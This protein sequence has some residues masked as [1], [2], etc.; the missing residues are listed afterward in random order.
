MKGSASSSRSAR[1]QARRRSA[2]GSPCPGW[3]P[4]AASA[5]TASTVGRRCARSRSTPGTA[6]TAPMPSTPPRT[7]PTSRK[8][9]DAVD[10]LDA[11]A[12]DLRRRHD[13]QGGQGVRCPAGSAG[14]DL[15]HRRARPPRAAVREDQRRHA[16]SPS[17]SPTKSSQL[18]K[19]LGADYVVN[20]LT[21]D[22]IA[23]IK[24]LGGAHA[25]ISVAVAP[26]AFE[27]A[28]GSLRRGGTLIF[29][30]LPADNLVETADLRDR[31]ERHHRHRVDR[32]H[33]QGP[34]RGVRHS[35][36]GPHHG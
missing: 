26:K 3:G 14:R 34:R 21:E 15:R 22:P 4:P 8:V 18:A 16:S 36:A 19:E 2:T 1:R 30:A 25:A 10:P 20:A 35:C 17:T 13:L 12:A 28:F 27:Q 11:S 29:V 7:P 9:P 24:A 33:P 23:A 6:G 32:R 5:S 31:A